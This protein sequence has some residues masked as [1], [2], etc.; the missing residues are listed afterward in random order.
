MDINLTKILLGLG[1]LTTLISKLQCTPYRS[2]KPIEF[3]RA[4]F[5]APFQATKLDIYMYNAIYVQILELTISDEYFTF[6]DL[7]HKGKHISWY[8]DRLISPTD[9]Q[10]L[11]TLHY[12]W[13]G[14]Y[15][16]ASTSYRS[17]TTDLPN[18]YERSATYTA[19]MGPYLPDDEGSQQI[20]Q[21]HSEYKPPATISNSRKRVGKRDA[22]ASPNFLHSF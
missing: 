5:R 21:K 1:V 15:S 4:F 6:R 22:E 11:T 3:P 14:N 8:K 16:T 19:F 10:R 18:S 7:N 12:H 17:S 2:E 13:D 20:Y 9:E